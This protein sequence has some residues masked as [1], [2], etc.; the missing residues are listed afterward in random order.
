MIDDIAL[1]F[2]NFQKWDRAEDPNYISLRSPKCD[3]EGKCIGGWPPKLG[4]K[5]S[6]MLKYRNGF[7]NEWQ[8]VRA[9]EI[10]GAVKELCPQ[11]FKFKR[12]TR[13]PGDPECVVRYKFSKRELYSDLMYQR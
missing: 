8:N 6:A 5:V 12:G 11:G 10:Q 7:K 9:F 13:K 3:T 2:E 1:N 4:Q